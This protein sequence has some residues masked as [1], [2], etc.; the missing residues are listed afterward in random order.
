M[1]VLFISEYLEFNRYC[2]LLSF[3]LNKNLVQNASISASIVYLVLEF[4]IL[5]QI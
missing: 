1:C 4:N 3:F 5:Q 2:L